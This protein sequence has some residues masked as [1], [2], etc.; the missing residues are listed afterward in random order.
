MWDIY[1]KLVSQRIHGCLV[2]KHN[3]IYK[4]KIHGFDRCC[5]W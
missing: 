3:I 5:S 1:V 2:F 4:A